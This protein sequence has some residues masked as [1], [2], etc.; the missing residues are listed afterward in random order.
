[1]PFPTPPSVREVNLIAPAAPGLG[2]SDYYYILCRHKWKII[3]CAILGF[4]GAYSIYRWNPP[5]FRSEAKLFIRYVLSEKQISAVVSDSLAKSPDQRGETIMNSEVEILTSTDLARQVAEAIGPE[6]ILAG[7]LGG[8]D[9]NVAAA[10]I[11]ANL[12]VDVPP[13]STVIHLVFR[14]PSAD[15]VQTVLRELIDRYLKLHRE[16][17]Q[18]VGILGDFLTQETD[19]LRARLLQTEDD[20]RKA[21]SKAGVVSSVEDAKKAY[22][23]QIAA[24]RLQLFNAQADLAERTSAIEETIRQQKDLGSTASTL[25]GA[26]VQPT[27]AIVGEYQNTLARIDSIAKAEADLLL[28]FTPESERAKEI[29][30]QLATA[31]KHRLELEHQYPALT[32]RAAPPSGVAGANRSAQ[33]SVLSGAADVA[34]L[35]ARIKVLSTELD[36]VTAEAAKIDD[37]EVSISELR[38][39][40]ELEEAN[41]RHFSETL[42]QSR[43]DEALGNG[44]VSNITAIENPTPPAV[45]WGNSYKQLVGLAAFGL[46]IGLVWAFAIEMY[47]D[48]SIKRPIDIERNLPLPLFLTLPTVKPS[49]TGRSGWRKMLGRTNGTA[50]ATTFSPASVTTERDALSTLLPFHETLRDRL[51]AYFESKNLTHKPKLVA[52]TSVGR[53]AGVTTIAGGLAQSLST[54]GEGNVLLVDMTVTRGAVRQFVKGASASRLDELFD[55][56]DG[57]QVQEKLYVVAVDSGSERLSQN[58]PQRFTKIAPKLKASDFDYIIFDM[59]PVSQISITPRLATYMDMVLLVVES[60][61]TDRDVVQRA[62]SMLAPSRVHIGAILNKTRTYGPGASHQ[63]AFFAS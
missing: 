5:P 3:L 4:V 11:K 45:D 31:E 7:T 48:R 36:Q 24:L 19:Q 18:S 27:S 52:I 42:E 44:R 53:K 21:R 51:I 40:K 28:H 41:Y 23:D 61:K 46:G 54:I 1:M 62:T 38:R 32:H 17:H 10:V 39:T 56:S 55:G 26:M 12:S 35:K 58:L 57:A 8:K 34:A 9:P 30:S 14:N 13:R 47:F 2:L 15:V 50:A 16:I 60:E 63:E 37:M 20:L 6:R 33:A 25:D 49:S 59:P 22:T 43:L 29:H